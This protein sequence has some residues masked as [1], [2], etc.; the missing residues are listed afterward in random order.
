M[1]LFL[2]SFAY[3]EKKEQEWLGKWFPND[4]AIPE[5]NIV[6]SKNKT[7]YD[8]YEHD[9]IMGISNSQCD[10]GEVK[11]LFYYYTKLSI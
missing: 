4:P 8:S 11:I 9:R 5:Q 3:T 7:D 2:K 10:D 1:T 6:S